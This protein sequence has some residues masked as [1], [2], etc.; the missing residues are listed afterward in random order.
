M[1]KTQRFHGKGHRFDP[2]W[3]TKFPHANWHSK[4]KKPIRQ[5]SPN[6]TLLDYR[7]LLLFVKKFIYLAVPGLSFSPWIFAL[8]YNM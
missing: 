5:K 2:W 1:V 8:R 7:I 4:K 3:S 6:N